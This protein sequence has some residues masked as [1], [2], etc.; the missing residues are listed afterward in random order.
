MI[1]ILD[2]SI[3]NQIPKEGII[4][5]INDSDKKVLIVQGSNLLALLGRIMSELQQGIYTHQ[6]VIEDY[7]KLKIVV[8]ETQSDITIRY[9]QMS[10][11]YDYFVNNGY[12][13]Y[14]KTKYSVYRVRSRIV[15]KRI[16]ST[17]MN[18][19]VELVST[20]GNTILVG[21]FK[22]MLEANEFIE[23]YYSQTTNQYKLP[24][25]ANNDL[26]KA[27]YQD[28][29]SRRS[30]ATDAVTYGLVDSTLEKI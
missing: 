9:L 6:E 30:E 17:L 2:V 27:Y 8:L 13:L 22:T 28:K 4:A 25:L 14:S 18:V 19:N 3:I 29:T 21:V 5:F 11:W 16:G 1:S 26:T 12:T 7:N 15:Y 23:T 20:R 10:Y 24:I